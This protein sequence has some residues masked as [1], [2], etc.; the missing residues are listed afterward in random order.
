MPARTSR[1]TTTTGT[2]TAIAVL[3]LGPSP[4]VGFAFLISCS[5]GSVVPVGVGGPDGDESTPEG[6]DGG[7][8]VTTVM[9]MTL[10]D[11]PGEVGATV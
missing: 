11:W 3:P 1:A 8:V 4:L 7:R 10:G 5:F 2:T 6:L 9:T